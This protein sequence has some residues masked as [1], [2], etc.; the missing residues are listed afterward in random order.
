MATKKTDTK[1]PVKKAVAKTDDTA[2]VN[3][4]DTAAED[5]RKAVLAEASKFRSFV[6]KYQP[7]L[8]AP[9]LNPGFIILPDSNCGI[10]QAY[11][12]IN[13]IPYSPMFKL[14]EMQIIRDAIARKNTTG[15][16]P[17]LG[18]VAVDK[19][20]PT[21]SLTVGSSAN[22][23]LGIYLHAI[24]STYRIGIPEHIK[25]DLCDFA[26]NITVFLNERP[27]GIVG[28]TSIIMNARDTAPHAIR[29]ANR[30]YFLQ[31]LATDRGGSIVV[32]PDGSNTPFQVDAKSFEFWTQELADK[33]GRAADIAR[34]IGASQDLVRDSEA[35]LMAAAKRT[36]TK[37]K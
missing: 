16:R 5:H 1:K 2:K 10:E 25:L 33:A 29:S 37:K 13:V 30:L 11:I 3:K 22:D 27:A 6:A 23:I 24:Y 18:Y 14:Q 31:D 12:I 4:P 17:S 19:F 8:D 36:A 15:L 21:D 9:L 20:I 35:K 28:P 32:L 34:I 7:G 26:A